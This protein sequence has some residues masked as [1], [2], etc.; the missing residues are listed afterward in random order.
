MQA[1]REYHKVR[2]W[3]YSSEYR[4]VLSCFQ[5]VLVCRLVN[6]FD[7]QGLRA[8]CRCSAL[9]GFGSIR[10]TPSEP[11]ETLDIRTAQ[12][13]STSRQ[14][15]TLSSHTRNKLALAPVPSAPE[16]KSAHSNSRSHGWSQG[17]VWPAQKR[18]AKQVGATNYLSD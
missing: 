11:I 2:E 16:L 8:A 5:P 13:S 3:S 18:Q 1:R 6:G 15:R 4:V 9:F 14:T 10:K 17:G 12:S 7:G